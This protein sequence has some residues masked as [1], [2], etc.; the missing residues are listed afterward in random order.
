MG[1]PSGGPTLDG[2][3]N[4]V[5]SATLLIRLDGGGFQNLQE[6]TIMATTFSKKKAD[7]RLKEITKNVDLAIIELRKIPR[8]K[9]EKLDFMNH[10]EI[11][12]MD[13]VYCVWAQRSLLSEFRKKEREEK[14]AA[15]WEEP[16]MVVA[17]N[18]LKEATD[19]LLKLHPDT[20]KAALNI[21]ASNVEEDRAN[22]VSK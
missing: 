18:E 4:S 10:P 16:A 1:P 19:F 5:Q 14:L 21:L 12:D 7:K 11:N 9:W 20:Q 8:E 3:V 13:Q 2:T 17:E 6:E 22:R 15:E